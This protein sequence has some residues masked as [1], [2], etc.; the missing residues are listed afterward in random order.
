MFK[1]LEK[2]IAKNNGKFNEEMNKLKETFKRKTVETQK[3]IPDDLAAQLHD[4]PVGNGLKLGQIIKDYPVKLAILP[5]FEKDDLYAKGEK[6]PFAKSPQWMI[7]KIYDMLEIVDKVFT[8]VEIPYMIASGTQLGATRHGGLI[9][10]DDDADIVLHNLDEKR[11]L[12]CIDEFKKQGLDLYTL[13]AK[14]ANN[15]VFCGYNL[16]P[17]DG[18]ARTT[19]TFPYPGVDIYTL[20]ETTDGRMEY[21]DPRLRKVFPNDDFDKAAWENRTRIPF[22]HLSLPGFSPEYSTAYLKQM[23]G[24][25]WNS[26]AATNPIDH[27]TVMLTGKYEH[28]MNKDMF[29]PARSSKDPLYEETSNKIL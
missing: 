29:A 13:V 20:Q 22:G 3:N 15:Y 11:F 10:W 24:E 9:P 19:T 25:Q 18:K 4:I 14:E 23:Y 2:S 6:I 5:E 28:V 1:D 12:E 27:T 17:Q 16:C 8:K 7:D 21:A 26:V